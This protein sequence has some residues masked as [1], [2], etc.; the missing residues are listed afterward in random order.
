MNVW[1]VKQHRVADVSS[2]SSW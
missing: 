1:L 2:T